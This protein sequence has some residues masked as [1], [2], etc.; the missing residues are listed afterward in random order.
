[1]VDAPWSRYA[2]AARLANKSSCIEIGGR[3]KSAFAIID[4]TKSG[5]RKLKAR[6]PRLP[7]QI[8]NARD[9]NRLDVP[10]P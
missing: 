9:K 5:A 2:N 3:T 10:A 8:Y 4:G 1:M 7:I 6:F